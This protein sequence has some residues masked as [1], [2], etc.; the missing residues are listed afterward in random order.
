M[1]EWMNRQIRLYVGMHVITYVGKD[2][3]DQTVSST[4]KSCMNTINNE[5]DE[6]TQHLKGLFSQQ[7]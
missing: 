6:P 5:P 3:I 2:A 1:Y 4:M 7:V